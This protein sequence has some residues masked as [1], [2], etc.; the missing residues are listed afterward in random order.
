MIQLE[1][2]NVIIRDLLS[3]KCVKPSSVDQQFVDFDGVKYHL[4]TP[5]RKSELLLSMDLRCWPDLVRPYT[6]AGGRAC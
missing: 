5:D 4:H 2:E 1:F 3:D 6:A